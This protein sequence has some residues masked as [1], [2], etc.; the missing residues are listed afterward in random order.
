MQTATRTR[1]NV[2][3][4]GDVEHPDF[5]DAVALLHDTANV[6][7]Q[8]PEVIVVAQSRPGAFPPQAIE[9]LRRSAPLAGVIALVGSWC[10]GETR[11][12]R[13]AAG[14]S[15]LY[16][17]EFP[18]WWRRQLVVRA[19]G[20]CP[21]WARL[22]EFGL[23]IANCGL[24]LADARIAIETSS[25][26]MAAALKGVLKSVG[27]ESTWMQFGRPADLSDTTAGIWEGGQLDDGEIERLAAFCATL[28]PHHAPVLALLDFPRRHRCEAAR[29]AGAAAVMGKPWLNVA[30]V[31]TLR[32]IA[33]VSV[34]ASNAA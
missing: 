31:D 21:E 14:V 23:R 9:R 34:K 11:S 27:A 22:D 2:W 17:Y 25:W 30:L 16:W 1:P 5:T 29:R 20:R 26:E 24:D 8:L 13:P 28:A 12:G 7:P 19:A 15:R 4:V 18:S 33:S 6:G 10:E 3:L 32:H